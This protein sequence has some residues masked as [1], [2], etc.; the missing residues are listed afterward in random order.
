MGLRRRDTGT[1]D[2]AFDAHA[3]PIKYWAL[4]FWEGWF[5]DATIEASFEKARAKLNITGKS[6]WGRVTGSCD[7]PRGHPRP[8]EMALD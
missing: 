1:A 2:P 8:I 5:D 4:A 6:I 7:G 3:G